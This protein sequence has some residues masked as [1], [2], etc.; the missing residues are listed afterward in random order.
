MIETEQ[1]TKAFGDK[2]V[3]NALNLSVAKG[4]FFVFLG[5]NGAGKTTTIKMLA[6]LL[7]P[8]S[9]TIRICGHDTQKDSV[10]AKAVLSYIP[11]QPYLYDKLS[12]EF[13]DFIARVYGMGREQRASA[14]GRLV[15]IFE[16]KDYVDEL[17]QSYSHGMKQRVVIASALVHDPRVIVIDEPMVGLDPKSARLAKEIF[18]ERARQG[19]T[20]FM[21]THTISLAEEVADRIGIIQ[22]GAMVAYGTPTEIRRAGHTDARLEDAFLRL[23]AEQE[24]PK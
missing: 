4:E 18:R 23:T 9:G 24:Q 3:V 19:V 10:H 11:D 15:E 22:R 14:I 21:S 6:G 7:L 20:L 13:L 17:C 16:M 5:P 2:V 1:L 12:G 8:T